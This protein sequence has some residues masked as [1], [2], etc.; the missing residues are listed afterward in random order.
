MGIL[1]YLGLG[2]DL[3]EP[4]EAVSKLYTTDRDRLEAEVKLAA[5]EGKGRAAQ[6]D[7]NKTLVLD[8]RFFNSAWQPLLGWTCGAL[9]LLYWAPQLLVTE[10]VWALECL[11]DHTVKPFPL[12]PDSLYNL[13]WLLFGFGGYSL[14]KHKIS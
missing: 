7:I 14:I 9:V 11:S 1:S 5:E 6:L 10:Y 2:K 4:I 3:A 12:A 8:G 13:V